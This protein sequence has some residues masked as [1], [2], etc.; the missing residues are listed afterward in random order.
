MFRHREDRG[1][2]FLIL[3]VCLADIAMY[4]FV[5]SP[6]LLIV[7]SGLSIMPKARAC[8]FNHHHQHISTF[9][10][11]LP[12]RLLELVYA[13]QTGVTSQAW[14]LHHSLG[15]HLNYLDQG[16]DESRWAR[17]DGTR[18]GEWEYSLITTLTAY[19]RAWTVGAKHPRVRRI[20]V[21]M[22]V[23]SAAIVT[24]LVWYRTIPGLIVFVATPALALF[25]T[26]MATWTHHSNRETS[27]HF[28]A[29]NNILNPFYN[30]VTGNLGYHTAHHYKPGVHW[31]QL[32][33]LHQQICD[34]IPADAYI[35]PGFPWK[36]IEGEHGNL[37]TPARQ[38][39]TLG[40]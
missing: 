2:V 9:T 29:C 4:L 28:V 40:R 21:T 32:P 18:M 15:H 26:A 22:A 37:A 11:A 13:L 7:Y 27:S 24:A 33:K 38:Q 34:K 23:L 20:F 5:D 10:T 30:M 8:A 14:V 31:S 39:P 6:L 25:G 12:N 19:S 17:A 1:P 35:E 16:K 36:L 3:A